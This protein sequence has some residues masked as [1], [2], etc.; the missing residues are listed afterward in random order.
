MPPGSYES[1]ML[2]ITREDI[3]DAVGDVFADRGEAYFARGKVQGLRYE[4]GIGRLT[5]RVQGSTRTPYRVDIHLEPRGQGGLEVEGVCSCPVGINCKHV[6]ALL[7]AAQ[8][9]LPEQ[10]AV[11]VVAAPSAGAPRPEEGPDPRPEDGLDEP[12]RRWLAALRAAQADDANSFADSVQNRVIYVLRVEPGRTWIEPV[13][14]RLTKAGGY[15]IERRDYAYQLYSSAPRPK[16]ITPA[17]HNI[18]QRIHGLFAYDRSGLEQRLESGALTA[19]QITGL[20]LD[21][22]ATGRC[23]WAGPDPARLLAPG[24]PRPGTARWTADERGDQSLCFVADDGG[25]AFDG[26]IPI[27]PPWYVDLEA[28]VCAPIE[29]GLDERLAG[30]LARAPRLAPAA[31]VRLREAMAADLP[32]GLSIPLPAAFK[33]VRAEA[34]P[35]VP[36]LRLGCVGLKLEM[37]GRRHY[38]WYARPTVAVDLPVFRLAFDYGG[39]IVE[40][41]SKGEPERREGQRIVVTP[42]DARAE[43]RAQSRLDRL[44]LVRLGDRRSPLKGVTAEHAE[45]RVP[46]FDDVAVAELLE[47]SVLDQSAYLA[48]AGDG[49]P[50]LQTEGWRIEEDESWPFRLVAEPVEWQAEIAEGEGW[51][52]FDLR[53]GIDIGGERFDL[54]PFLSGLIAQLPRSTDGGP[55]DDETLE[56]IFTDMVLY[57]R[58]ADGRLLPLA[59]ERLLLP[60][61][62]LFALLAREPA[63]DAVA[64]VHVSDLDALVDEVVLAWQGRER[65]DALRAA[66]ASLRAAPEIDPP[67]G[68]GAE[69][70]PYQRA[71]LAWL[72]ALRQAGFGG[73]LADDMG[74]G[75]TVQALAHLA[76][77]KARGRLSQPC[78]LVAPTSL[79][80]NWWREAA[81]FAPELRL[82]LWH[83]G[84]RTMRAADL[85]GADLVLTTYALTRRD[86]ALLLGRRWSMLILDEAQ[87]VKNPRSATARIIG[88]IE[89]GQRLALTGTPLENNLDELWSLFHIIAPGLLGDLKRFRSSFRAPIEKDRDA[90]ANA[91]LAARIRPFMLRR[92]KEAVASELPPKTEIV[93]WVE[94]AGAQ[95]D[96]YE[97]VRLMMDAKVRSSVERMGLQR[98][99]IAILDALLKLRQVCCDPALVKIDGGRRV[100]GSIKRERL[101]D[102]LETLL[103]EGR[104]VLLFS[105]F[106]EMLKLIQGDLDARGI[107][108]SLLTGRTRDRQAEIDRFEGGQTRLFLISLK[109]GG[110][111]LNLT[112]ADTVIIYDPWWNPAV[113]SQ[114]MD[115]AH[116]IGQTKPVFVYKLVAEGTVEAVI[117]E[118]QA[119]KRAL[120]QGVYGDDAERPLDLDEEDLMQLLAPIGG[121]KRASPGGSRP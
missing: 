31:T 120:A 34:V 117:Q 104:R 96:L 55:P 2:R 17:D 22:L 114:A 59:G 109:A 61:K 70:R 37:P 116:R 73:I 102:L 21:I 77:E 84:D 87:A 50:R 25:P 29:T 64:R 112:S 105:Q 40:P 56:A 95:R 82:V 60:V 119:R 13:K 6:A 79:M 41:S 57:P 46:E 92:T 81:R 38:H 19:R 7:F 100:Q 68:F 101:L 72:Q 36:V 66:I 48:I 20:I 103:A 99:H 3:D 47:E 80:G 15:A 94:L 58:L 8:A 16:F 9:R 113:E 90:S 12:A 97:T 111:G 39:V 32:A 62:A 107:H 52:W 54:L 5:G 118:M 53:L 75:K 88:R 108:R 115:R 86:E 4:E 110:T 121:D 91:R 26:V 83:G 78:L 24:A 33:R 98:S 10:R 93:D 18:L 106:V 43:A 51:G 49:L 76:I 44:G 30:T 65:L 11:E 42:R 85:D 28:G 71:G 1:R 27:D 69:L 45:A 89:A 67:A 35:P 74:L 14:V 63:T 23:C